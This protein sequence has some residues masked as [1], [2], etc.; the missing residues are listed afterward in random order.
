MRNW[1]ALTTMLPM[2]FLAVPAFAGG[3]QA[4]SPWARASMSMERPGVIYMVLRNTGDRS[5]RLLGVTT[6]VAERAQLHKSSR[7]GGGMLMHAVESIEIPAGA[8]VRLAPGG[9]HVM[10]FSLRRKLIE[11][12]NF[13]L[14]LNFI[15][16]GEVTVN[17]VISG[18]AANE[19]PDE[20]HGHHNH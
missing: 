3:V 1:L 18:I 11:G 6:P 15:H 13:P 5:D 16:A 14:T 12:E 19:A 9:L 10:L 4:E 20:H 7:E 17:V 2:L 8:T